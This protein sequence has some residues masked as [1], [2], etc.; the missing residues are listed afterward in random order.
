M[1]KIYFIRANNTPFG[2]AEN[3]LLRLSKGLTKQG[4]EHQIIY[5]NFSKLL[6]SWVRVI[7]FNIQVFIFKGSKL[8]F[9]LERITCADIYRAG[10]GVHKSFLNIEKKSKF[11]PLHYI[12]LFLEKKCFLNSTKIIANSFMVKNQ[13]IS[14]YKIDEKKIEVIYN[15]VE[16]KKQNYAYS[17]KKISNEFVLNDSDCILL[18]IGNGFKRKGVEEFLKLI[19]RLKNKNFTA[20]IV[21]KDKKINFYKKL[22]ISLNIE[23]NII[24]TGERK[25]VE[26]F[27]CISDIFILPTHYD[28]FS[29]VILEAMSF[30]NAVFTTIQ[31]GASEIL[32]DKFIM[33][34]PNDFS[35]VNT[36]SNLINNPDELSRVK[37]D[38]F[39]LVEKFSLEKNIYDSLRVVDEV[40]N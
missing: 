31:N 14:E 13:I 26:N 34:D 21:G 33:S 35:I 18:Y 24:F 1:K 19:S 20:F 7:L 3:Y 4:V 25:D 40:I 22:A 2:G 6:P 36:I 27:Y 15:G 37:S 38:N 30:K 28:P 32:N 5:S 16:I 9:S 17:L 8:Y 39:K 11:N 29:N 23:N 12:Y 10:D